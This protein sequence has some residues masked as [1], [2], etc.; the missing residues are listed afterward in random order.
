M[1]PTAAAPSPA[2]HA[3]T[4]FTQ[5]RGGYGPVGE[6]H[7]PEP[8][9]APPA[10]YTAYTEQ[11]PLHPPARSRSPSISP[12]P[13]IAPSSVPTISPPNYDTSYRGSGELFYDAPKN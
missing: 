7:A 3:N 5:P 6:T 1:G 11:Q 9:H 10:Q 12:A 8:A 4:T 2:P 13:S